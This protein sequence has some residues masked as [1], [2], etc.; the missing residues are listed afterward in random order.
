MVLDGILFTM[1]P[2]L[3]YSQA[4]QDRFVKAV[5][6][7][8]EQ[9][10]DG[11]FLDVGCCH[12]TELS[13]THA[14]EQLGWRGLLIDNDPGA[15]ALCQQQRMS[16]ATLFNVADSMFTDF[17]RL[18]FGTR[19]VT[20]YLSL[21]VDSATVPAL[22]NILATGQQFRVI[23]VEHDAYRFGDAPRAAIRKMLLKLGY[24]FVCQDVCSVEGYAFEDWFV[25]P[26]L[27]ES[28]QYINFM[29]VGKKWTEILP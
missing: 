7:D 23:T 16:P 26:A 11:T 25:H 1:K 6:V 4:G 9:L 22:V 12:P 8:S 29:C 24:E 28:H 19:K 3:S 10:F 15:I 27:V 13:N 5:L 20:D 14:L 21:D 17:L 2:F 18:A